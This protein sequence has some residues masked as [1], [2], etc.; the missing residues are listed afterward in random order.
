MKSNERLDYY[1]WGKDDIEV[2]DN[3]ENNEENNNDKNLK[4]SKKTTE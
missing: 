4:N 1:R 3:E 2:F